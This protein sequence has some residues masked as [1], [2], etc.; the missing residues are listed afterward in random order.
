[1]LAVLLGAGPG[2]DGRWQAGP[3]S[4]SDELGGFRILAVSGTGSRGDPVLLQQELY[5]ASAVVLVIRASGEVPRY[6]YDERAGT[7][8]L[9]IE[10][11]TLNASNLPWVEFEFELQELRG[12]SSVY[13]D[14][15]SFDQ[16]NVGSER[17]GSD[18]FATH[19]RKLEPYDRLLFQ[20][21]T[22]NAGHSVTFRLLITDL[23]PKP[24]FYLVQDPRIP[25]S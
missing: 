5:T 23:T 6:A 25:A 19:D 4:F 7:G 13:G 24:V 1:M 11:D 20:A 18:T 8:Y 16:R 14:G 22:V 2:D 10:I 17:I 21:G 3:Y 12:V 15:L 9:F